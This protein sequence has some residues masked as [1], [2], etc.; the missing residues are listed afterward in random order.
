MQVCL[1]SDSLFNL[2]DKVLNFAR[3]LFSSAVSFKAGVVGKFAGLLLDCAFDLVNL[4]CSLIA[5]AQFHSDIPLCSMVRFNRLRFIEISLRLEGP[6]PGETRLG[7][8]PCRMQILLSTSMQRSDYCRLVGIARRATHRRATKS[9]LGCGG[10]A[11]KM[12]RM[13]IPGQR[14]A[15]HG[16][17]ETKCG[18]LRSIVSHI[19]KSRS[20][21]PDG[22]N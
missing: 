1:F 15:V 11:K 4:A 20:G 5:R 19:S 7:R 2:A 10:G 6:R 8:L 22:I 16:V 12:R 13:G 21:A 14:R 9:R 18:G 17:S 3:V